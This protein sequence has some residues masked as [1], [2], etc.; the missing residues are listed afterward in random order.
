MLSGEISQRTSVKRHHCPAL[1]TNMTECLTTK[2]HLDFPTREQSPVKHRS[3]A[4]MSD[5]TLFIIIGPFTEHGH[6]K[7]LTQLPQTF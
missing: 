1:V 5:V 2:K 4:V 6:H 3:I 7:H